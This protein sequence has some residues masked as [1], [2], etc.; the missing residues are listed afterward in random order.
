MQKRENVWIIIAVMLQILILVN[1][2][3]ANSWQVSEID[4]SS[5]KEINLGKDLLGKGLSLFFGIFTLKQIGS[6]SAS[7]DEVYNEDIYQGT[8][9][10][11]YNQ[12]FANTENLV[13]CIQMENGAN[14]QNVPMNYDGCVEGSL[15]ST[16]CENV[17]VCGKVGCC[18]DSEEAI[19]TPNTLK[20]ECISAGGEFEEKADCGIEQ[21]F[22]GCCILGNNVEWITEDR[23][24]KRTLE[25]GFPYRNFSRNLNHATCLALKE[26]QAS[27]ACMLEFGTCVFETESECVADAGV[28]YENTLCS[29][30]DLNSS[31]VKQQTFG[32]AEG[33]DEIYWFDSCGNRENIYSSD[34]EKSW[35]EG[36][37]LKKE[38][39]C[40]AGN[41]NIDSASCGNCDAILGSKCS[42]EE[43]DVFALSGDEKSFCKSLN[44][45]DENGK[46]R[47]N[48]E[49]WCVYDAYIGD[50]KDV[51]GS[52]HWRRMC[53]DGEVKAEPCAD[54]RNEVCAQETRTEEGVEREFAV[55]RT[56]RHKNC[57]AINAASDEDLPEGE[58]RQSMCE[59][60]ADCAWTP[61][62]FGDSTIDYC[63]PEY[64]P[65][66]DFWSGRM[67]KE[68][69]F[70]KKVKG[71][72]TE[73]EDICETAS[74]TCTVVYVKKCHVCSWTCEVNCE[75]EKAIHTERM[76]DFCTSLG[77]CGAYVNIEEE[78]TSGAYS[79]KKAPKLGE[80]YL[81]GL[82]K[83]SEI[84]IGKT[85]EMGSADDYGYSEW[86]R[87]NNVKGSADGSLSLGTRFAIYY[88][89]GWV[90]NIFGG[91]GTAIF[92]I[93]VILDLLGINIIG[94]K[95][96]KIKVDFNCYPWKAP[97]ENQKC[98]ECNNDPLKPCS[99]YRCK[100]LGAACDIV[101]ENTENPLCFYSDEGDVTPPVISVGNITVG[102][103]FVEGE[104]GAEIKKLNDECVPEFTP[105]AFSIF[106][107]EFAEC[108]A[109]YERTSGYEEMTGY[110]GDSSLFEKE[111][112]S[113]Y[114]V[115]SLSALEVYDVNGTIKDKFGKMSMYIRCSDKH[116]NYNVDEFELNFCIK[117]GPDI[118]APL[119]LATS[120]ENGAY[121][122]YNQSQKD[123]T[124]WF[125]EPSECRWT[126]NENKSFM[127]MEN[128]MSC[129]TELLEPSLVG[130]E[131]NATLNEI[132]PGEET[133]Y[134]IKCKDQPWFKDIN[135][136]ARNVHAE[137]IVYSLKSSPSQ[138]FLGGI[139]P[140]G[141]ITVGRE[142]SSF[143]IKANT[144]GGAENGKA[145]CKFYFPEN[146]MGME[147]LETNSKEHKQP[148]WRLMAGEYLMEISC[149]DVAGNRVKNITNFKIELDVTPP[150]ITRIYNSGGLKVETNEPAE[151][152]YSLTTCL[153]NF[154]NGTSMTTGYSKEHSEEWKI[155]TRYYI[156]C[157]DI[158]GNIKDGCTMKV[159]PSL[160]G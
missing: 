123:V 143:D 128:T 137:N 100:S 108:R 61:V 93:L 127:E 159:L 39:S 85:A 36:F 6:V 63:L 30:P 57:I 20:Q 88:V 82:K 140:S 12:F 2:S 14:C 33:L 121:V 111:H 7:V 104:R 101:N 54:Y 118:T 136:S 56:N 149:E 86:D 48:G 102:Y 51:V 69:Q 94:S 62:Q 17:E 97:L 41:A 147:F 23:C 11:Q 52:R 72:K 59:Q 46:T 76:N 146:K 64:P 122:K 150:E 27:G 134:Y 81:K 112:T 77:D 80:S 125:A 120:P 21:C 38:D 78:V 40:G 153:F 15:V 91:P 155:N 109:E 13:C 126:S 124:F 8:Y 113:V 83:F 90:I 28:F 119:L 156:R 4:S 25:E 1:S 98:E 141:T 37:V 45:L 5:H 42:V 87:E 35:N 79:I 157:R 3:S 142:P 89:I 114:S 26:N 115:P 65:G 117:N 58:T 29:H 55:C 144:D 158:F 49:S 139:Y 71:E 145:K 154:E 67:K 75:C 151:C 133:K 96:K 129:N 19:C 130:W 18:I 10:A 95:T 34:R 116:G 138:L 9:K 47:L 99:E 24:I 68:N 53:I 74:Q 31:C 43:K 92:I 50:S 135:E 110:F 60:D 132:L 160:F 131:C 148:D 44:C 105:I 84:V 22:P 66:L 32:C 152:A 16:S 107:D 103:K 73:A 70:G 106:T